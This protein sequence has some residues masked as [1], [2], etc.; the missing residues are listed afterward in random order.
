MQTSYFARYRGDDAVSIAL[1]TPQ[2]YPKCRKYPDLFPTW[3]LIK[4]YKNDKDQ[5]R[6][7]EIYTTEILGKLD[8]EKVYSD[9]KNNTLLCWEKPGMFCHRRVVAAW[10]EV[11][12]DIN[13][14]EYNYRG[15]LFNM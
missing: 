7:I 15:S 11:S 1:S 2:W 8:P 14:P 3:D 4:T 9:L 6:Y 5:D 12:L 13:V 10:L